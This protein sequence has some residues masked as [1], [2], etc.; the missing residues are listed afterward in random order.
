MKTKQSL[1]QKL[2][3]AMFALSAVTALS[4]PTAFAATPA[5]TPASSP[6][7][8]KASDCQGGVANCGDTYQSECKS[9]NDCDI[10]SRYVNPFIK[11]LSGLVG[12]AVAIGIIIG[13]IQLS[14]SA[15]DPQKAA[16]AKDHIWVAIVA[17]F[18]Y[19]FL[20]ALLKFLLPT[21]VLRG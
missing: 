5:P 21:D 3:L 17:L 10:V 4:V 7:S 18:T 13:G 12:V 9:A 8:P 2:A 15:G 6:I 20:Y 19:L 1:L 16:K 11:I 14:S